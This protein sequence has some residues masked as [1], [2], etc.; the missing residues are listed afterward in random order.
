MLGTGKSPGHSGTDFKHTKGFSKIKELQRKSSR[1]TG[2]ETIQNESKI[3]QKRY[4][5]KDNRWENRLKLLAVLAIF[6]LIGVLFFTFK[7]KADKAA[8][9]EMQ[10]SVFA[11]YDFEKIVDEDFEKAY[12]MNVSTGQGYLR[13]K[14]YEKAAPYFQRALSFQ[15]DGAEANA[16]LL[17]VVCYRCYLEDINCEGAKLYLERAKAND[18]LNKVDLEYLEQLV[19]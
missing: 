16:G 1:T 15:K 14:K 12:D 18:W 17:E 13:A 19:P 5:Q 2:T 11:E 10:R 4:I 9:T 8:I 3:T 6:I 7:Q